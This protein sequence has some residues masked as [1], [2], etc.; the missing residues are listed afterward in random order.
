MLC[1]ICSVS[2]VQLQSVELFVLSVCVLPLS[3]GFLGLLL[4]STTVLSVCAQPLSQGYSAFVCSKPLGAFCSIRLYSVE[5][6]EQGEP[7]SVHCVLSICVASITRLAWFAFVYNHSVECLCMCLY[8]KA[9]QPTYMA[10]SL[11]K[12]CQ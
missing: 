12:E 10:L 1:S 9:T 7:C 3:Q 8:H 5:K 4:C 11:G 6:C 2:C